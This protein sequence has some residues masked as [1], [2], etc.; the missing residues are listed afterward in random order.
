MVDVCER[1]C[2]FVAASLLECSGIVRFE[3]EVVLVS[4]KFGTV[5]IGIGH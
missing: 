5:A 4:F 3:H 2:A 1:K